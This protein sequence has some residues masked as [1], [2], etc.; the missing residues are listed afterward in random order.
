MKT[1]IFIEIDYNYNGDQF[2]LWEY[3]NITSELYN[4]IFNTLGKDI[5]KECQNS[6]YF[7][8]DIPLIS[9]HINSFEKI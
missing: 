2:K 7:G 4:K 9:R 1:N 8:S 5:W 3:T 6:W